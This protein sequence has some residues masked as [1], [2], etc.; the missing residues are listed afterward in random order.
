MIIFTIHHVK[1][2][3]GTTAPGNF[4]DQLNPCKLASHY[5]IYLILHCGAEVE[6]HIF[7]M[8]QMIQFTNTL[9]ED[10]EDSVY[11]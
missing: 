3:T 2:N 7:R 11:W 8:K 6:N 1:N 9:S 5:L 4:F 10:D